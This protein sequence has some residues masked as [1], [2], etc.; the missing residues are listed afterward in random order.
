MNMDRRIVIAK[1]LAGHDN[2]RAYSGRGMNGKLC[3]GIVDDTILKACADAIEALSACIADIETDALDACDAI[4][5]LLISA[6]VDNL[7]LDVIVYWP[8]LAWP[9]EES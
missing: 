1:A 6:R 7:G 8:H 5:D 2:A 3:V 9:Q 4:S